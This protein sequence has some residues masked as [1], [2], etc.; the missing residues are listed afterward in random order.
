MGYDLHITRREFW[1]GDG[2]PITSDEWL[3]LIKKDPDLAL[4]PKNGPFFAIVKDSGD[5]D[6][7]WLD[8]CDGNI[9]T[10]NP[11]EQHVEK[12]KKLAKELKAEVQGDDGEMY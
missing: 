9:F 1:A 2:P 3:G 8:W 10:K 7:F 11:K 5:E 6:D 4:F 12:M